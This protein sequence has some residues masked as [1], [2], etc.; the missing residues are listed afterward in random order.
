MNIL[1]LILIELQ[2]MIHNQ[3]I[4]HIQLSTLRWFSVSG[5]PL[6]RQQLTKEP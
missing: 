1:F 4:P 5:V 6:Q 3:L 2:I